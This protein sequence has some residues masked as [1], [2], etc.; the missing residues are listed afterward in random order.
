MLAK[1]VEQ[2][3][4]FRIFVVI[5]AIVWGLMAVWGIVEIFIGMNSTNSANSGCS[6]SVFWLNLLWFVVCLLFVGWGAARL[7]SRDPTQKPVPKPG[8]AGASAAPGVAP[9]VA[10]TAPGKSRGPRMGRWELELGHTRSAGDIRWVS[11]PPSSDDTLTLLQTGDL[12][13]WKWSGLDVLG[14]LTLLIVALAWF[15]SFFLLLPGEAQPFSC[16]NDYT[17]FMNAYFMTCALLTELLAFGLAAFVLF[18][19]C[20]TS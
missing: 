13:D 5:M 7:A 6:A 18:L 16:M 20:K 17:S 3:K 1:Y 14:I 11:D 19:L 10:T 9:M 8:V 12:P 4:P 15:W 2:W